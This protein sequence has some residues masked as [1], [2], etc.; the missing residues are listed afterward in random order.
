VQQFPERRVGATSIL[1]GGGVSDR[2]GGKKG[3]KGFLDRDKKNT[4]LIFLKRSRGWAAN[5][6]E[7]GRGIFYPI[8]EE[9]K[10]A[11]SF[12]KRK[13]FCLS[14][15]PRGFREVSS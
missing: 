13:R 12:R 4:L 10:I 5:H 15:L 3:K 6:L 1:T 7:R 9:K 14:T 2:R 8:T 11:S